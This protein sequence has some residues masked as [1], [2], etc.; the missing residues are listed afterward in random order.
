[1]L[2]DR[3]AALFVHRLWHQ[4]P[5]L[6]LLTGDYRESVVSRHVLGLLDLTLQVGSPAIDAG[7][8]SATY[9]DVDGI[10]N[11]MGAFGGPMG[12]W[13]PVWY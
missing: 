2:D 12:D 9:N 4:Q 13:A 1:M 11:D 6:D 8:S 5:K 10:R 7:K 3:T